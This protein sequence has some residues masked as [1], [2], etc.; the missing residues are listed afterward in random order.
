MTDV[1]G[2]VVPTI[3]PPAQHSF[4]VV[5]YSWAQNPETREEALNLYRYVMK[6]QIEPVI[7]ALL[8]AVVCDLPE[9]DRALARAAIK[10]TEVALAKCGCW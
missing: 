7:D 2:A 10:G 1:S 5:Q 8:E 4:K 6:S 3:S 9:A